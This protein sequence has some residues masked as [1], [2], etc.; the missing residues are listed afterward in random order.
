MN[1]AIPG[2]FFFFFQ[3]EDGIRDSSVT[4]VQTCALPISRPGRRRRWPRLR[5]EGIAPRVLAEID[6]PPAA[7]A[8]ATA[9]DESGSG[10]LQRSDMNATYEARHSSRASPGTLPPWLGPE[11]KFKWPVPRLRI[12]QGR[13]KFRG[14]DAAPARASQD[15]AGR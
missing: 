14:S 15:R 6:D 1:T 9:P 12:H 4:G 8:D 13:N 7:R 10:H 3:A 5:S 11:N 2:Y